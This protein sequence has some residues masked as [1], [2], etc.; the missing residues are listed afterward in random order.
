MDVDFRMT[1]NLLSNSL[2]DLV[3]ANW[4]RVAF[5]LVVAAV[6]TCSDQVVAAPSYF[7][8]EAAFNT[9]I[10]Q[11]GLHLVVNESFEDDAVWGAVRSTISGGPTT[12]QSI[13]SGPIVWR[14]NNQSSEVT[15]G[16]GPA[17]TGSWGFFTIPHGSFTAPDPGANCDIPGDCGDG[18]TISIDSG[19]IFAVGGWVDTNT[20]TAK[21]GVFA[22]GYPYFGGQ[23][24]IE[25]ID[26]NSVIVG[27]SPQFIGVMD[28]NGMTS[29]EYRELEG[30]T[31]GS[32]EGDLKYIFADDFIIAMT[33]PSEAGIEKIPVPLMLLVG[34]GT[35]LVSTALTTLSIRN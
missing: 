19:V 17:R 4:Q 32:F 14:A 15:T 5:L 7:T 16:P 34:F 8:D 26:C 23:C 28:P 3:T 2:D 30:K 20:P 12:A 11:L 29:V 25:G 10:A 35:F 21:V 31:A 22:N 1:T 13:F 18:F 9:A 24:D 6:I 27:T 33:A